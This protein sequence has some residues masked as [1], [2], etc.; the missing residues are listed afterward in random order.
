MLPKELHF[1]TLESSDTLE[2][3]SLEPCFDAESNV[4]NIF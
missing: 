2:V 4:N 3:D 1:L